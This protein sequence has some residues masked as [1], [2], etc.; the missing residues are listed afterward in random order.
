M[1]EDIVDAFVG[2][3]AGHN[4]P[5]HEV[6]FGPL[7]SMANVY[8]SDFAGMTLE[9]VG[10]DTLEATQ[11]RL[12]RDLPALLSANHREFL[13]S[14]VRAEPEWSLMPYDHLRELP[15]IRWKLQNLQKLKLQKPDLFARQES[16]LRER[17]DNA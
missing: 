10:L 4:R 15:A 14:L 12:H 8:D 17:F 5:T 11:H 9:P 1:R 2:Y 16:L 6:L 13:L 7:H 3:L